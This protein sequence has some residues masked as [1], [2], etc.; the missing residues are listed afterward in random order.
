MTIMRIKFAALAAMLLLGVAA[1]GVKPASSAPASGSAALAKAADLHQQSLV[2]EVRYRRRHWREYD[3]Y[4]DDDG[5]SP[6]AAAA[7]FMFGT[8]GSLIAADIANKRGGGDWCAH[9]PGF[10][11]YHRTFFGPDGLM[12][13]CPD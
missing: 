11:P 6:G 12:Y 8:I 4:D 3:D 1:I 10:N 9:Q 2:T 7:L 13:H 5:V